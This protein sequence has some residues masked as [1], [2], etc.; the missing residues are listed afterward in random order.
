VNRGKLRLSR[1]YRRATD[2]PEHGGVRQ[3]TRLDW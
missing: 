2:L 1:I 3:R